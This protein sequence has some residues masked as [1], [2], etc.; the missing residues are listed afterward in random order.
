M[1]F[2]AIY[3]RLRSMSIV[4]EDIFAQ[5]YMGLPSLLESVPCLVHPLSMKEVCVM[6]ESRYGQYLRILLTDVDEIVAQHEDDKDNEAGIKKIKDWSNLE[7]LCNKAKINQPFFIDLQQA[8]LTF[9][10]EKVTI[11]LDEHEIIV[12]DIYDRKI[13]SAATFCDFQNI[14]RL[15]NNRPIKL[16]EQEK[17][18]ESATA[19]KFRLLREKR[20]AVKAKQAAKDG[21]LLSLTTY[22]SVL[23]TYGIGITPLNVGELSVVSFYCLLNMKQEKTKYELDISQ[24]LAGASPKKVKPVTWI[25]ELLKK[26]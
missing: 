20:E 10:R 19:R 21:N 6:G 2:L 5:A 8:L 24:L 26:E 1:K 7:Y 14:L 9:L 22:M 16:S 15:Q 13:I 3:C 23:C 17:E 4:S 25:K 11:L 12:G 18:K